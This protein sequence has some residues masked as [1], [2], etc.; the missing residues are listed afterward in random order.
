MPPY[1]DSRA[2]FVEL[3]GEM[4]S[5]GVLAAFGVTLG[6]PPPKVQKLEQAAALAPPGEAERLNKELAE[7]RRRL[8]IEAARAD[9]RN[10]LAA[11]G[12]QDYSDARIDAMLD[13]SVFEE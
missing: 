3:V 9:M 4:R 8:R 7:E 2:D 1:P 13:P 12:G 6:P 10:L 5:L 11:S